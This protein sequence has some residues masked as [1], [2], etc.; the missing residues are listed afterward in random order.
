MRIPLAEIATHHEQCLPRHDKGP[1]DIRLARHADRVKPVRL[2]TEIVAGYPGWQ[3]YPTHCAGVM[4]SLVCR[5]GEP[6][7]LFWQ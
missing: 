7:P 1:G 2:V 4:Q 6:V 5:H 3:M